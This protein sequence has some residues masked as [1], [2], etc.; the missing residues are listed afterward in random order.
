M[1]WSKSKYGQWWSIFKIHVLHLLQWCALNGFLQ[2]Q[3]LVCQRRN[4]RIPTKIIVAFHKIKLS[5]FFRNLLWVRNGKDLYSCIDQHA[6]LCKC[7]L[8]AAP[9]HHSINNHQNRCQHGFGKKFFI[10]F[11]YTK[12]ICTKINKNDLQKGLHVKIAQH[13]Y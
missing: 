3:E 6:R 10:Q 9:Y 12:M 8:Y 5:L 1:R 2:L 7:C 13:L 11:L 4:K